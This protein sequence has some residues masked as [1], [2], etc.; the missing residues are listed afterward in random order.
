MSESVI[1]CEGFHDRAFWAGWLLYLGCTDPGRPSA[2]KTMRNKILDPW[3]TPVSSGQYAYHS[4]T[5]Q[6][7]R[8][9]PC[10]GKSKILVDARV[11]L[12][13]RAL[14]PLSR[15][16][17][18]VD[19]DVP[20]AGLSH[21]TTGLRRQDIYQFVRQ[22]DPLASF[23]ANGEIEADGGATNISLIRWET[24][25]QDGPG[26]PQQQ[27]LERL[28][29]AALVAAFPARAKAVHDWLA[30]RPNPPSPDPKEHAWSY[31]A[32]WAADLGCEAF[33]SN[34]W[35]DPPVVRELESRLRAGGAWQTAATLAS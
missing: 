30:S 24:N 21:G 33:Y 1:L 5:G 4:Q 31:M 32:G 3:N 7:I 27:T 14:K 22:F 11:Y 13:Q 10:H 2:G 18:N 15:L 25:D 26:L 12:G 16:I 23:T 29:S 19:P 8:V 35:N 9:V 6:F 20:A 28:V 17:I 34:L